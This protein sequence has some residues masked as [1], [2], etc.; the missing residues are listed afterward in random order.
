MC[1]HLSKLWPYPYMVLDHRQQQSCVH[2]ILNI[3]GDCFFKK[4][5]IIPTEWCN[6]APARDFFLG[7]W[8]SMRPMEAAWLT[9]CWKHG[10]ERIWVGNHCSHLGSPSEWLSGF[11]E[12]DWSN[13]PGLLHFEGFP[14]DVCH[15]KGPS[16]SLVGSGV[17]MHTHTD[18]HTHIYIYIYSYI[19][20]L[21]AYTYI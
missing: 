17:A 19:Y 5:S 9:I 20:Y 8:K 3:A 1:D 4:D 2:P 11:W 6:T 10:L 15:G 7:S 16:A 21:K 14:K 18:P 13:S 12:V